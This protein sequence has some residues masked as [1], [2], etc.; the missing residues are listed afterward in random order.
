MTHSDT[1]DLVQR[2]K[3]RAG[4]ASAGD[5]GALLF[6]LAEKIEQQQYELVIGMAAEST[7]MVEA[8]R[9]REEIAA[10]TKKNKHLRHE[11][12]NVRWTLDK[13]RDEVD[14]LGTLLHKLERSIL[15]GTN[16]Q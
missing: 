14:R 6:E 13:A 2:A 15:G 16:N 1:N 12:D 3:D 4:F 5:L 7:L 8:M 9:L 11:A 10:L